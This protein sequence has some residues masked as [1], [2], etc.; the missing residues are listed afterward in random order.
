M[1]IVIAI[2]AFCVLI[3]IHE[4][5]H[6]FVAKAFNM[7]VS[8]F[9]IGM[10]P[11]LF[12]KRGK[13]TVY[14]IKL[15][16]MGGSVQLG[17]DEE[18]DDPR[19]FRNKPV[20]Q[21]MLVI[22]AGAIMNLLL[23][24]IVCIFAVIAGGSITTTT[25]AEFKDNAVSNNQ[26]MI[27][28]EIVS[29]NGMSI[30]TSMDISY[31]FQNKLATLSEDAKSVSYD[32]VVKRNNQLVELNNV[33]FALN[34]SAEATAGI[35]VDFYVYPEELNFFNVISGGFKTA[36]TEGRLIWITLGDFIKGTY[37][38]N[39]LSGPVGIVDSIGKV[40]AISLNSLLLMIAFITIN[41]GIFN[42][43]PIPSLDGARFVFLLIEAIRRKPIKAEHEGIVHFVGL[44]AMFLLFIVVTFNDIVRLVTGG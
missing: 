15:I 5:G 23:G 9:S 13:E 1:S 33:T 11:T 41:V 25:V 6:F 17:E 4:M 18:S 38:I 3:I 19:S 42:L 24:V 22:V 14:S 29:I 37:G 28:D 10:G 20:W 32:F 2:L 40:A 39:D 36:M 26:L 21:R 12:R 16:P 44:C 8:E 43:L 27:D 7:K 31:C 30:W 34:Q 35:V